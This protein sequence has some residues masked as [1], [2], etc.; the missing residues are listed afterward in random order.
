M[1]VIVPMNRTETET[2]KLTEIFQRIAPRLVEIM[3]HLVGVKTQDAFAKVSEINSTTLS[4]YR[5]KTSAPLK[6]IGKLMNVSRLGLEEMGWLLGYL[7]EKE[8]HAHRFELPVAPDEI[9]EPQIPFGAPSFSERLKVVMAIDFTGLD[10]EEMV[11]YTRQRND[12]RDACE[13][14]LD[15]QEAEIK[16]H[17]QLLSSFEA[18]C[19]MAIRRALARR[20]STAGTTAHF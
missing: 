8:F 15:S 18:N 12:L 17:M 2:K 1:L 4:R 20:S 16:Q 9:K 6:N 13:G 7:L 10:P 5:K 14:L 3:M 11:V 19:K